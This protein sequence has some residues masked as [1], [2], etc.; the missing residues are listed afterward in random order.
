MCIARTE[1]GAQCSRRCVQGSDMCK[2]H[3]EKYAKFNT[4]LYEWFNTASYARKLRWRPAEYRNATRFMGDV[5]RSRNLAEVRRRMEARLLEIGK[6]VAA[7]RIANTWRLVNSDPN[8][9][10]CRDRL[11]RE[12]SDMNEF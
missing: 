7:R 11:T 4:F 10:V 5:R 9:R 2:V 3:A 12:F 1:K 8:Y 6:R